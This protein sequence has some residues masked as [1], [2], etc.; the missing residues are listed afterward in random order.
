M[1][2]NWLKAGMIAS[3]RLTA[4][5]VPADL[6]SCPHQ[7]DAFFSLASTSRTPDCGIPNCL[8]IFAGV[9]PALKA[10][11]TA[12]CL[13]IDKVTAG[14][15]VI[16]LLPGFDGSGFLPRR[17][18]SAVTAASSWSRSWSLRCLIA[19]GRSLGRICRED[20]VEFSRGIVGVGVS[21]AC[22]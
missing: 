12:F 7:V 15:S 4:L 20:A 1:Y 14:I 9:T 2:F 21:A 5:G 3:I 10:A 17:C 13:P 6:I 19:A 16:R 18:C 11:R 22:S 8:A